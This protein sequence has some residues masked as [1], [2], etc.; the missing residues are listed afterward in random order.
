MI[1]IVGQ[2][3]ALAAGCERQHTPVFLNAEGPGSTEGVALTPAAGGD[4]P[5]PTV[6][7]RLWPRQGARRR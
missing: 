1:I 6:L 5:G 7:P 2:V 4:Q 3:I